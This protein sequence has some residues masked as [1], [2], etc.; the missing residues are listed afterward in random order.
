MLLVG[1]LLVLAAGCDGGSR[2]G[3]GSTHYLTAAQTD[4]EYV[5]ATAGLEL[6]PGADFAPP[7]NLAVAGDGQPIYYEAGSGRNDAQYFWYCAWAVEALKGT[8]PE[9]AL[10]RMEQVTSMELWHSLDDNGRTQFNRQVD[11]AQHGDFGLIG[12]FVRLN[13]DVQGVSS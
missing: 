1:A 3:G 9:V 5:A 11:L 12:D 13:C 8:D 4:V 7:G 10:S 6:P 2:D